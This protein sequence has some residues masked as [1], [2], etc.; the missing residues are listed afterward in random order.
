MKN[1]QLTWFIVLLLFVICL[2]LFATY[3]NNQSKF[4]L[5]QQEKCREAGDIAYKADLKQY[6]GVEVFEPEYAYNKK[7]NTCVYGG[8][9]RDEGDKRE[10]ISNNIFHENC[11]SSWTKWVKDSYTNKRIIE[12][13]NFHNNCEWIT[14]IEEIDTYN[15][16]AEAL[17]SNTN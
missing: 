4:I 2:F 5:L 3:K 6:V 7:L 10:G 17:L 15:E 9:Y 11:N 14:K 13:M 12:L 1:K 16:K 8:G